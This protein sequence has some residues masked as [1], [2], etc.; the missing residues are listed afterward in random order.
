MEKITSKHVAKKAGVST[1][2]V[3]AILNGTKG[4]RVSEEK[5]R[6][7]LQV[8]EELNYK[9]DVQARGLRIGRTQCI[10]V[11][12]NPD[13]PFLFQ[14][15]KGA[16]QACWETGYHLLLY[17]SE[18]GEEKR[19]GI[20][21]LYAQRRIDGI[22]TQDNTN[23]ND[24]CWAKCMREQKIP[25]VSLEGYPESDTVTSVIT[26]YKYSIEYALNYIYNKTGIPPTYLEIYHGITYNPD[27]GDQQ[28]VL[29]Y[30]D[31]MTQRGYGPILFK[32]KDVAWNEDREW[33]LE[34]LSMQTFPIAILANWSRGA[35]HIYRAAYEL[36]LRVGKELYIMAADN[37]EGVN[38]HLVPSLT[39][40][41]IPY[42]EMGYTAAS[43]LIDYI[44]GNKDLSEQ[45]KIQLPPSLISGESV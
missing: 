8:I 16:Q 3:S 4:I 5:R 39:S 37:T 23:Y 41:E 14:M 35:I 33:W 44:E 2:V 26:N 22:L 36:N 42:V 27:W 6:S 13:S 21:D 29:A 11:V 32:R 19:L 43:R 1:S 7:V 24:E 10:A 31:W 28:R 40:I 38:E 15:M 9:V 34:W 20:L 25:Y 18:H 45:T 17:G 12:G 30:I